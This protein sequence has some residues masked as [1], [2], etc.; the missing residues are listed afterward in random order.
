MKS[1]LLLILLL[2]AVSA[3]SAGITFAEDN[4]DSASLS[5]SWPPGAVVKVYFVR[6][7]FT[8]LETQAL[9]VAMQSWT[10]KVRRQSVQLTFIYAGEA[11]GLVDCMQCLTIS[12]QAIQPDR[13]TQRV[14]LNPL[15]R[16]HNGR[17]FS[18]WIAFECA[19][20]NRGDVR[21]VITRVLER[22]LGNTNYD[23][24]K[25]GGKPAFCIDQGHS[26]HLFRDMVNTL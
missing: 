10:E 1:S 13:P 25:S 17:L 2:L 11:D 5:V 15:R 19:D 6:G 12:R 3:G 14:S 21:M 20:T 18:A 9:L 22:G 16:D 23:L 4:S 8:D 7:A 24:A 26:K